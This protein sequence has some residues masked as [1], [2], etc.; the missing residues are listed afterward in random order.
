MSRKGNCGD[1][2]PAE[3][4]FNR[5]KNERGPGLHCAANAEVPA[6]RFDYVELF[7]NRTRRHSP[8]DDT[9]LMQFAR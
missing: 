9:S 6:A 2:G 3:S 4:G 8:L 5:I 1:H 7:D